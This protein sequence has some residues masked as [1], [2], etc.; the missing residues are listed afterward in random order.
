V[1]LACGAANGAASFTHDAGNILAALSLY[2][3]LLEAPGVLAPQHRHYAAELRGLALRSGSLLLQAIAAPQA[4][5]ALH[6]GTVPYDTVATV[7]ALLPV[8]NGIA[9]PSAAVT[10]DLPSANA[11]LLCESLPAQTLERIVINLVRNAAQAI[12]QVNGAT[13]QQGNI[14]VYLAAV[15]GFLRLSVQDNGPGLP[16]ALAAAFL[17]PQPMRAGATRGFGHRIVHEL[18]ASTGGSL[19]LRVKPGLG[20]TVSIKWPLIAR[21]GRPC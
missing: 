5:A 18:T 9:Q 14:R 6:T 11:S 3:D 1:P 17:K 20:T 15:S 10:L 13:T 12:A 8:L 21:E 7:R 4:D 19:S 16:P 2:C